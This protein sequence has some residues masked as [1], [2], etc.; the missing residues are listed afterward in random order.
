MFLTSEMTFKVKQG[1]PKPRGSIENMISSSSKFFRHS[2]PL[3]F[4]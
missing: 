4:F 2:K 1:H 3:S